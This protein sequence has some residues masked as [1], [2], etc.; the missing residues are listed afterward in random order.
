[1][2]KRSWWTRLWEWLW[3][4]SDNPPVKIPVPGPNPKPQGCGCDLSKPTACPPWDDSKMEPKEGR[5]DQSGHVI[6][7]CVLRGGGQWWINGDLWQKLYTFNADGTVTCHCADDSGGR[8][9]FLGDSG[10]QEHIANIVRIAPE[11]PFHA[12]KYQWWEF[13]LR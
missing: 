13:R 2:S 6:R 1:M 7:P 8:L 5:G 12:G 3:S 4:K 9:H 10:G 11:T